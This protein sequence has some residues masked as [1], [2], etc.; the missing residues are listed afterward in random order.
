MAATIPTSEPTVLTAGNSWQWDQ[1]Y[2]DYPASDGWALEYVLTGAHESV[3]TIAATDNAGTWEIRVPSATTAEYTP[4]S[5]RLVGLVSDGTDRHVVYSAPLSV[6]PDPAS[7]TPDEGHAEKMLAKIRARIEERMDE[8][9]SS[10]SVAQRALQK[11]DLA[12]LRRM[13]AVYA[14]R[15]SQSR[16]GS[17]L[18]PVRVRFGR[19]V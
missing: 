3:I 7:A 16:G 18:Q 14:E 12:Q 17:F 8:D 9:T 13:E 10:Y 1:T 4:G 11:E 19:P 6:L 15:V 2:S 5:F